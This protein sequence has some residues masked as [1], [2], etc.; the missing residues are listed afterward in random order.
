MFRGLKGCIYFLLQRSRYILISSTLGRLHFVISEWFS[1]EYWLLILFVVYR[2]LE[3]WLWIVRPKEV[4]EFLF[5]FPARQ[6]VER[7]KLK[8]SF[9]NEHIVCIPVLMGHLFVFDSQQYFSQCHRAIVILSSILKS[10]TKFFL[11]SPLF[12]AYI[13]VC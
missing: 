2:H 11:S 6:R 5:K 12:N 9:F 10:L 4:H 8:G 3:I 1:N 7:F 13:F